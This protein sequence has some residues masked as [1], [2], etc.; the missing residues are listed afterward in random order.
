MLLLLSR[1]FF[2]GCFLPAVAKTPSPDKCP[3]SRETLKS[4]SPFAL[5][6]MLGTGGWRRL[7]RGN[8]KFFFS[9]TVSLSPQFSH[10]LTSGKNQRVCSAPWHTGA[11]LK[12]SYVSLT[13]CNV[14]HLLLSANRGRLLQTWH[15]HSISTDNLWTP[16]PR[17]VPGF[18]L[19]EAWSQFTDAKELLNSSWRGYWRSHRTFLLSC[20][21]Y[22]YLHCIGAYK[23][24]VQ[25]ANCPLLQSQPVF[26]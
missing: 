21:G 16:L 18:T 12:C 20:G 3:S 2:P 4:L 15:S 5:N 10:C 22:T 14:V 19:A 24:P 11:I 1:N 13:L 6:F 9:L 7:L 23:K 26:Q 17:H 8:E 25:M